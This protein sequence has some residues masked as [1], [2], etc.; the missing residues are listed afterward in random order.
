MLPV[1]TEIINLSLEQGLVPSVLKRALVKPLLK[2]S[3]LDPENL[4]NFR[5]VSNLSYLSKLIERVAAK[6]LLEHMNDHNLHETFQS[7]YKQFHSTE[8]ALL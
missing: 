6:R 4:K 5:P 1:L 2:E 7:A 3:G 8:T